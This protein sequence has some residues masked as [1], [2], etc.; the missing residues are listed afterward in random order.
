MKLSLNLPPKDAVCIIW[1]GD[2][3]YA[4]AQSTAEA[5]KYLARARE[6]PECGPNDPAMY[7]YLRVSE[8]SVERIED[9]PGSGVVDTM[10]ELEHLAAVT[11][12]TLKPA[13]LAD[14][15][16][17]AESCGLGNSWSYAEDAIVAAATHLLHKP[18]FTRVCSLWRH[19]SQS[20]RALL[21]SML[22]GAGQPHGRDAI[23]A[24]HSIEDLGSY[25]EKH[26]EER[27]EEVE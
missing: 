22:R 21:F 27:H 7:V 13:D 2:R 4:T 9:L 3:I 20:E 23:G 19:V 25:I 14:L 18:K 17:H 6:R 16:S 11:C 15:R 5:E 1:I 12:K 26:P 10:A 24:I 8:R